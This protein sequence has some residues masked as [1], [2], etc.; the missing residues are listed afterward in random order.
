MLY[1]ETLSQ[2]HLPKKKSDGVGE[3]EHHCRSAG[4]KDEGG[5]DGGGKRG[6]MTVGMQGRE[7]ERARASRSTQE[8]TDTGR[9]IFM[10]D[11]R[12]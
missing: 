3:R 7:R 6:N 10:S 5:R 11:H 1:S 4:D 2:P 12:K 9:I 8:R